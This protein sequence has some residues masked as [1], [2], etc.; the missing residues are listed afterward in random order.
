MLVLPFAVI[1]PCNLGS[2]VITV[3]FRFISELE[4]EDM[5][6][7]S[8]IVL[9]F[10]WQLA[11]TIVHIATAVFCAGWIGKLKCFLN[12]NC[13]LLQPLGQCVIDFICS[14]LTCKLLLRYRGLLLDFDWGTADCC[15]QVKICAS[16]T[17]PGYELF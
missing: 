3:R 13:Y 15:H 1:F 17:K 2:S 12:V 16:F 11:L 10:P 4:F 7:V 6:L 9:L 14:V 5:N 8:I